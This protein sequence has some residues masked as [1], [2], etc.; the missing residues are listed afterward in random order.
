M[1]DEVIEVGKLKKFRLA[2]LHIRYIPVITP[3]RLWNRDM[4]LPNS[5]HVELMKIFKNYGFDKERIKESRYFKDR[6]YRHKYLDKWTDKRIWKH[7]KEGRYR[8]FNLMAK[9]G[10]NKKRSKG[11]PIKVLPEPFW[12]SRFNRTWDWIKGEEIWNGAGRCSAAYV[13]GYDHLYC[14]PVVDKYANTEYKGKF[15]KKL[16]GIDGLWIS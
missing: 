13:L 7:I 4:S 8:I 2:D 14:Q 15:E 10:W 1:S 3:P 6:Q 5:P 9:E 12:C 16:K 11:D